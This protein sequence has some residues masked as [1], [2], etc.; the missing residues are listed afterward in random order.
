M[1]K[2][3]RNKGT[4]RPD[5]EN[6]DRYVQRVYGEGVLI[7]ADS[8]VER[9]RK[10]IPTVL[11]LDVSLSGGIPEGSIVLLSGKA[12][13]GK[14]TLC[15]HVLKNAIDLGRE[16]FYLNIERRC[17][18]ELLHTIGGLDL[19]KLRFLQSTQEVKL[20]AE[21]W[22]RIL[23]RSIKDH[24]G[25]VIVVDSL[26]ALS[27]A[28][29]QEALTGESRDL[30]GVPKLLAAFFRKMS[31]VIDPLNV[32][33]IFISQLMTNRQPR[34]P[35][36]TEKGGLAV[37]YACSV[38]INVQWTSLWEADKDA[39]AP[40]GHDIHMQVKC[41]A[42]GRPFI[43]C[44]VPLRFGRGIDVA[45]DVVTTGENLGLIERAGA[46]YTIPMLG[47][48]KHQGINAVLEHLNHNPD[49]LRKVEDEIRKVVFG[50]G[51][52]NVERAD[53]EAEAAGSKGETG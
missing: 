36:Y 45:K 5:L 53:R 35:R 44:V 7:S 29:E 43:P 6:F 40:L 51:S 48:E 15:L 17:K 38:W 11:S 3:T 13:A 25:A 34:G 2:R 10:I 47:D 21:Q 49:R 46:W 4:V 23:E 28:A 19:G 32:T 26:A 18:A 12:K 24:P 37:Q 39:Q 1:A 41:S 52:Q 20:T 30:A 27:T 16:A 14:T 22:L 9:P 50:D 42:L 31:E 8:I 33:L